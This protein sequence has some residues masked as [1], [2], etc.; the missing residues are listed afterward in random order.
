MREEH[1]IWNIRS[2]SSR[3]S[4]DPRGWRHSQQC[5][6]ARRVLVR[7]HRSCGGWGRGAGSGWGQWEALEQEVLEQTATLHQGTLSRDVGRSDGNRAQEWNLQLL[8]L[9]CAELGPLGSCGRNPARAGRED[10]RTRRVQVLD[11]PPPPSSPCLST[12]AGCPGS[13]SHSL[14]YPRE[15][16]CFAD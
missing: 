13:G 14:A 2:P 7:G 9:G 12:R 5:S 11:C 15:S 1:I 10:R 3:A 6:G 4:G 16:S 8:Q